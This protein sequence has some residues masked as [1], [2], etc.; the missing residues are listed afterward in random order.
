MTEQN[1]SKKRLYDAINVKP[2]TKLRVD[3]LYFK[4]KI[5]KGYKNYDKFIS[6]ILDVFENQ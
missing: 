6:D 1:I 5:E 2:K 4:L 3:T